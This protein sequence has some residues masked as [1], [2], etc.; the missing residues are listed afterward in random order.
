MRNV[1]AVAAALAAVLALGGCGVFDTD[2]TPQRAKDG[3]TG[4]QLSVTGM[5]T[6]GSLSAV[7]HV[8]A[9]IQS[10]D[11]DGLAELA[12]GGDR[13]GGTVKET[14]R[15]W[16]K[17]WG[18]AAQKPMT[19]DFSEPDRSVSVEVTFE[20]GPGTLSMTLRGKGDDN[21]DAFGVVLDEGK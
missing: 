1:R 5:P 14:A 13:N 7:E 18:D 15:S 12:E 9:R 2:K 21:E 10:R 8:L 16:V 19:A 4:L 20:G 3:I 6:P 11:A 17:T